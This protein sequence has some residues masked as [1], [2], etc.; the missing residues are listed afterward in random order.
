MMYCG[1]L[2][3]WWQLVS[4]QGIKQYVFGM[5]NCFVNLLNMEE[6]WFGIKIIVIGFGLFLCSI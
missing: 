5:I 1:I 6:W 2:D 4:Y 3:L